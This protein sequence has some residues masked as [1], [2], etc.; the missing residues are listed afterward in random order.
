MYQQPLL[1][2]LQ[3]TTSAF[4]LLLL[5]LQALCCQA[6]AHGPHGQGCSRVCQ[7]PQALH[8]PGRS[9]N[10]RP[11]VHRQACAGKWPSRL[12]GER[13]LA[14]TASAA[15]CRSSRCGRLMERQVQ[16]LAG[17]A[18]A[19]ACQ[20]CRCGTLPECLV[21]QLAGTSSAPAHRRQQPVAGVAA[22]CV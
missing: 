4:L 11:V 9:S 8:T 12:L 10:R 17:A 3:P 2:L 21:Q 15:A 6:S 20:H 18:P 1:L 16:R 19:A 22:A 5:V 7:R 14:G 13:K